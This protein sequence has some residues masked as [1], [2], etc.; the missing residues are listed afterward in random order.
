[1]EVSVLAPVNI[2]FPNVIYQDDE[3]VDVALLGSLPFHQAPGVPTGDF[4]IT[5][6]WWVQNTTGLFRS[7]HDLHGKDQFTPLYMLKAIRK[8]GFFSRRGAKPPENEG[9]DL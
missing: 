2:H 1:M 8:K 3:V 6:K 7:G 4:E 9:D 5:G